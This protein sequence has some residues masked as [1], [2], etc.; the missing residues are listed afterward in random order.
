ML[1]PGELVAGVCSDEVRVINEQ[2]FLSAGR[3]R[4]AGN[5]EKAANR[6]P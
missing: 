5:F 3:L 4:D 6:I 2:P 1:P